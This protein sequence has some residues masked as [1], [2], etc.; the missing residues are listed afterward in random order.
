MNTTNSQK[1]LY[2][3]LGYPLI[4]SFSNEK[5][6]AENIPAEYINFEID[7]IELIK[8]VIVENPELM[9]LNVTLPY[10]EAVIPYMNEMD[11]TA[12]M[13]GAVNVIK[14]IREKGKLKLKGF[15]SDRF[16][17]FYTAFIKL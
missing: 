14:F 9:G 17:R 6:I 8:K 10:K 3:L 15:N 11:E 1:Q 12:R 16:Y 7:K 5:F 4:H 13:I 2:G